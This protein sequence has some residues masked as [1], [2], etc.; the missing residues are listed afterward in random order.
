MSAETDKSH[1]AVQGQRPQ[2]RFVSAM[3]ITQSQLKAWLFLG[4]DLFLSIQLVPTFKPLHYTGNV[5]WQLRADFVA[6]FNKRT[7]NHLLSAPSHP[8]VTT[9][10]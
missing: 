8:S 1:L 10:K 6:S 7:G 5:H 4:R 9:T 3:Q 2:D